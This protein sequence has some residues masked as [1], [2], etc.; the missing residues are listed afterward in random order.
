[1]NRFI[2]QKFRFYSFI[3]IALLLFVHGYNLKQTYLEPFSLVSERLTFTTFIE[4]FLANGILRFRLPM[5]FVISGFIFAMQDYKPYKERIKKRFTTLIIPY[6]IWSA[7]GLLLTYVWQQFPVTAK[8]VLDSQLDQLG[9]NRPYNEIGWAGIIGRWLLRPVS[10]Q[11]WFI[12]S[13]FIYNLIYP[14][15]RWAVINYPKLWFALMFIMWVSM[16]RILFFEGQG[17]LFFSLGV[18]LYKHNYPIERKP[19]WYSRYLSW[20]CF[21]GLNVIK[22]FMAFEFETYNKPTIAVFLILHVASVTAFVIAICYSCD[23]IVKWFMKKKWFVWT[24]S[25]SFIIYGLHIPLLA[26]VMRLAYRYLNDVP[27][28]RLLTYIMVPILVLLFC[29]AVGALFRKVWPS[30]YKVATGGRGF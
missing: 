28:Y 10:F 6:F 30:G 25:F 8:A 14:V 9:D 26:Y 11:L 21:I 13:L 27:N 24:T 18:W 2:S 1:M 5:L 29:I 20:L 3:S 17:M 22:T 16:F 4:Y 7:I 19:V 12:R 23:K 15:F